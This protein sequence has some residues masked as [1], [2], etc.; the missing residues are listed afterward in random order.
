MILRL[1]TLLVSSCLLQR[2]E[3]VY[4]ETIPTFTI[5]LTSK[6]EKPQ[7]GYL[8][9][10]GED[11]RSF[12]SS[13][14]QSSFQKY[15]YSHLSLRAK[16]LSA[17][18][19]KISIVFEGMIFFESFSPEYY[20][21]K[22]KILEAFMEY[23]SKQTFLNMIHVST[24]RF[25]QTVGD[26]SFSFGEVVYDIPNVERK[27][28]VDSWLSTTNE[29]VT[30]LAGGCV[31]ILSALLLSACYCTVSSKYSNKSIKDDKSS[32]NDSTIKLS[33]QNDKSF[34]SRSRSLSSPEQSEEIYYN[35]SDDDDDDGGDDEM[36]EFQY[37]LK[38]LESGELS[39]FTYGQAYA[40]K[41]EIEKRD[42]DVT[43]LDVG[44]PHLE[45]SFHNDFESPKS[46][47][48]QPSVFR[49]NTRSPPPQQPGFYNHAR[50]PTPPSPKY[51]L[52]PQHCNKLPP[53]FSTQ[54][55][56]LKSNLSDK[57][58]NHERSNTYTGSLINSVI[59]EE[60]HES[61]KSQCSGSSSMEQS[62]SSLSVLQDVLGESEYI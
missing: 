54:P 57:E 4:A 52:P 5:S 12:L 43:P 56:P 26:V 31:G 41:K 48:T 45:V 7:E 47:V 59:E 46:Q 62:K 35:P 27:N 24:D 25:F 42:D 17:P 61:S 55:T 9:S 19:S 23:D 30:I 13:T 18:S 29:T 34:S 8:Q 15:N 21:I 37:S 53:D 60:S 58:K 2:S 38:S 44:L 40:P 28:F 51:A 16:Q 33:I 6:T 22:R 1:L 49:E 32:D 36:S 20:D 10:L 14:L 11:V 50:Y 39:V 3:G